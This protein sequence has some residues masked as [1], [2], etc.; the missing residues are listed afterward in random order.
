[1]S[2]PIPIKY[3][4][5]NEEMNQDGKKSLYVAKLLHPFTWIVTGPTG[6]GKT[7]FKNEYNSLRLISLYNPIDINWCYREW[8]PATQQLNPKV[9]SRW[10]WTIWWIVWIRMSQNSLPKRVIRLTSWTSLWSTLFKIYPFGAMQNIFVTF[11]PPSK[12][13]FIKG[14]VKVTRFSISIIWSCFKIREMP[15]QI[16]HVARQ[17]FP[18]N[19][20]YLQEVYKDA[21]TPPYGYLF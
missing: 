11:P 19:A 20:Q 16:N 18:S 2:F 5:L 17:K 10:F 3:H 21:T 14:K 9:R 1:M 8:Q 4:G 12:I 13:C 7:V 15:L 6:C